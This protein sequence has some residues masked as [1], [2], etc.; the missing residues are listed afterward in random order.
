M[1]LPLEK[2]R[3]RARLALKE[4][5]GRI[6]EIDA[7]IAEVESTGVTREEA[8]SKAVAWVNERA[9]A[10]LDAFT[11]ALAD[12]GEV[13]AS[14]LPTDP[15]TFAA[16]MDPVSLKTRLI[17]A[18]RTSG[19]FPEVNRSGR[20]EQLQARRAQLAE[21]ERRHENDVRKLDIDPAEVQA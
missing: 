13:D 10:D 21:A 3:K 2:Q 4:T 14:T 12:T 18:I 11:S 8:E 15:L 6:I 16:I 7:K 1:T 17:E 19:R 5:R 9:A 20:L